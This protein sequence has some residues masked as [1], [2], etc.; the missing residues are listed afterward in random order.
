MLAIFNPPC[1]CALLLLYTAYLIPSKAQTK[2]SIRLSFAAQCHLSS[3]ILA[4]SVHERERKGSRDRRHSQ[5][6]SH[7][8]MGEKKKLVTIIYDSCWGT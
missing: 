3:C 7:V 2:K 5:G 8:T 1:E 6:L 4:A